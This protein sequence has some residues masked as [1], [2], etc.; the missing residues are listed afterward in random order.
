MSSKYNNYASSLVSVGTSETAVLARNNGRTAIILFNQGSTDIKWYFE[1]NST[2]YFVLPAGE[3]IHLPAAPS[4]EINA[5]VDS[6][7]SALTVME[8]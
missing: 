1:D 2:M 6:G 5:I 8:S 3:G 7:T 4:N